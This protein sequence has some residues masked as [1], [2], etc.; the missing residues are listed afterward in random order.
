M[1]L[2]R[3]LD[4]SK[5]FFGV[6]VL[7]GV[8][9]TLESGEVLGLV[10]ENGAGKSTV[11]KIVGGVYLP[12]GGSIELDGATLR[13]GRPL[14]AE[15]V[16]IATVYQEFNLL[17]DATVAENI[18]L[19]REPSRLGAVN[20]RAME[21]GAEEVLAEIGVVG[22][23][24][25]DR[26]SELSVAQQ[27]MVEIAKAVSINARVIQMDEPTSALADHEVELLF[28]VIHRLKARG[29][30]IVYVSHRLREVFTLC[31]RVVILKDGALVATR[32]TAEL[33]EDEV[34]RLMVGRP[35]ATYFPDRALESPG[36]T[37]VLTLDHVGNDWVDDISLEIRAG[38][39]LGIAGLQGS[40]RTEL[41]AGVFGSIP[42]TRGT[43]TAPGGVVHASHPLDAIERGIAMI[44]EDRKRE[45]LQMEQSIRDN[46]LAVI[47][48]AF[49]RRMGAAGDGALEMLG[50]LE[51]VARSDAQD[52]KFLSGGN[53]QKVVLAKW[54]I[55][56][57]KVLLLDEPTRGIDVGA[58]VAIYRLMRDLA[59]AGFA[60]VMVSSELPEVIGM[61]D[62]IAVMRDGTL[63]AILPPGSSE[64]VILAAAMGSGAA[65]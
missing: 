11:M 54:L 57:P 18:F 34:V 16:G 10:G 64:V 8:D 17:P 65:A 23:S 5:S 30:G 56:E 61:A 32:P 41:L 49:P 26:V 38:E 50:R 21:R 39:I 35:I 44:P 36:R 33:T 62:R 25:R 3:V 15:R 31:D 20:R 7:D 43:V 47:R 40:G 63:A 1:S 58:K 13:L 42:F 28:S 51:V 24:P 14:D 29:V 2:L 9:F 37:P 53:Q 22:I 4:L 12:D 46:A 27:Q 45:G 19:G 48:A 60:V 59:D 52:V 6:R 55:A